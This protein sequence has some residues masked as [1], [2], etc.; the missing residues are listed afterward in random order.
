MTIRIQVALQNTNALPED[1]YVN[2]WHFGG[3]DTIFTEA[4]VETFADWVQEFYDTPPPGGTDTHW[5]SLLPGQVVAATGHTLK[6][7][8]LVDPPERA[9]IHQ[10]TFAL[11]VSPASVSILPT[12]TALCLS[13]KAP[14][15]SGERVRRHRGRIYL[16]P[17][18]IAATDADGK[19]VTALLTGIAASAHRLRDHD[20]PIE[21]PGG[22]NF[23]EGW[24]V[25]SGGA[26]PLD[27]EGHVVEG[28]DPLDPIANR[29]ETGWI[30]NAFDT[31]RRRGQKA[32]ARTTWS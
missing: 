21:Q 32:T 29:V 7:Y 22:G 17:W 25:Y 6:C 14:H 27:E 3:V 13:Y 16:G 12:E 26:K 20:M 31:Q 28:S 19:P 23:D 4:E 30:D 24:V 11:P 8:D 18:T 9:V 2:V 1:Q 10:R 15:S 5:A